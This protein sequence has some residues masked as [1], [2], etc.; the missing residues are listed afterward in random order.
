LAD[1]VIRQDV[2]EIG[3]NIDSDPVQ[4]LQ[5][6]INDI[7]KALGADLGDDEFKDLAKEAKKASES[8]GDVGD[9][10]KQQKKWLNEFAGAIKNVGKTNLDKLKNGLK[11][12]STKLS[13]I[14]KK[15]SGAVYSG[16]KKIAGISFKALTVG[17]G[18]ATV[19]IGGIVA[20]ST[21]AYADFEQLKGGVETLFGAKGATS[22]EEY[23]KIVGKSVNEA[24]GEYSK[25]KE[26]ESTVIKYSN[27]AFKDA[28]LSA[29]QYMETVTSFSASLISSV[30]GDTAKAAELAN[31]A[32]VD[33]SDNANKMGTDMGMIQTAYQGFAKQ[34]YT[35]LDNLKLGYG[36]T[37]TEMER[38]IKDAAKMEDVQKKLGITVDAN[39]MSYGN[40]VKAIHIVQEQMY[41]N[42]TTQKEAEKT[43]TGSLNM[44]KS[45][46]GNLM[47]ALIQ[48]GDTFDQCVENLVYSVG[49]FS[50]NIMPAVQK[51]LA[52]V[53]SLIEK[54]APT[55]EKEFP[56]IVDNLLPPLLKA[57][58]S[59]LVSLIKSLPTIIKSVVKE[60]PTILRSVGEAIVEAFGDIPILKNVGSLLTNSAGSIAKA[61]PY[62]VGAFAGFKVLKGVLPVVMGLF[63]KDT[64][65]GKGKKGGFLANIGKQLSQLGKQKPSAITKGMAN[66]GII[67]GGITLLTVAFATIAPLISKIGDT[68]KTLTMV[69]TI[70]ALG[71][72]AGALAKV[73]DIVG[74]IPV[75]TVAKGLANMAIMLGGMSALFL[76]LG[77]V[78][79]IKF[80]IA[81]IMKIT[82]AIAALGT[83]GAALSVFA[84]IVGLIP[85]AV[86]ALGLANIAIIMTG[87]SALFLLIGAV[88]LINF[89]LKKITHIIAIIGLLGTVGSVLSVFAGIVGIIPIPV[90]LAGLANIGL[91]IGGM[92]ALV[93]A[94]GK[95]SEI[96]GFNDFITKGGDTLANLF[97]QIGKIAGS[98]ISGL[99][100]G[101]TSSLPKIGEN[102]SAF[103]TSLKPMFTMFSGADMSGIGSFFKSMGSFM[104]QMAGEGILSI[105]TGGTE[106]GKLGTEL[107][108]FATN[109]QGFFKTVATFP[110]NGFTNATKLFDCL[111]GMKGL[112]KEGGMVSWFTG[113]INYTNI[114]DGLSQLASE[115]VTTFF[116]TVSGLKQAG[117]DMAKSLFECLGGLKSLP[118]D[119]G[120]ASWF[121]GSVNYKN[122]ADGLG[123]LGGEGVK[124]FFAMVSGFNQTTFDNTTALFKSLA[125]LG[126]LPTE[127]GWWEKLTSNETTSLS[128]IAEQLSTFGTKTK[129]FFEQVNNL[130]IGKLNGLWASLKKPAELTTNISNSVDENT[131]DI[132]K[133]ISDLPTKMGE[134]LKSNKKALADAFVEVWKNAVEASVEPVNKLISGANWVLKEFGSKKVV[135]K[136]QP[137]AKG[138]DGHKGGNALVNDGRGAELVQMPNGHTFIPQGR[139]VFLPN[140]P[141]GMKVLPAEQTAQLMGRAT[142]SYRYA[143]GTGK[144]DIWSYYDNSKGLVNKLAEQASYK[145]LSS[146]ASSLGKG[147]VTTISSQ[148]TAWVDKLFEEEGGKSLA[149]Y[150][151][152]KGV[153]QWRSTVARALKMEG[154]YSAAN[155]K[156]TLFQM[157]TESGGN[158]RAINLWD[159]NAK[160]GTPSKGL[161]QVIDP[162]FNAYARKGFNKNIYDPLSNILASVR[163][164]KSRYGSLSKAYRGVGYSKG[165]GNVTLPKQ[166]S[167]FSVEYTPENSFSGGRATINENN[168]YAPVFNLT[169]SGSMDE[170]TMERK[171]KQWIG[172]KMDEVFEGMARKSP[173]LREV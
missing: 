64:G 79:L 170:R 108:T 84:G 66:L 138:T 118:K 17:L 4:Q 11:N 18:A 39:S 92:S 41:I 56:K 113:G 145:G 133:K 65:S 58:T 76:L 153:E 50:D 81:R 22:V 35:M 117:F 21:Q 10:V 142:P 107:N 111:A 121:T 139:N 125:G 2:V 128:N 19:A 27:N 32:I 46:W 62:L 1:N 28:G 100:E 134:G 34:N 44:V 7:K 70:G 102:L 156:R 3:F 160:K 38:L 152:S 74:K 42:G 149:S 78:S 129:A 40:I 95:L 163:Y 8:V 169:I 72:V 29:N 141:K 110:E 132:V 112:P 157:Q 85:V 69:A 82:L 33:M 94:F 144:I 168:T 12:V 106:L 15:T 131:K 20:K 73:S 150:V 77:A 173:R 114:A 151:A 36:G 67:I 57:A 130:N 68:G 109:S 93:V 60:I 23:A 88:S 6:E 154:Q 13:E 126:E 59:L 146:L 53:G 120:M 171:V 61:V 140:A 90:V 166:P 105:F 96:K 116:N 119:G 137:Y 162:T 86:V 55:L 30:G 148:M 143:D 135:A 104:L 47:P 147:M 54:L 26:V 87:L 52:G 91:V 155:V 103:A 80:D 98:L 14:A 123:I 24:K 25:L 172:E 37:K 45:A 124:N 159:S 99:G 127:N 83:V 71:M 75:S 101:L 51:A 164:A 158:P 31:M 5:K 16:L 63:S 167:S 43:I 165:V 161:M 115:K 89:D 136:W 122:I 49:K 97:S 48:G 9:N